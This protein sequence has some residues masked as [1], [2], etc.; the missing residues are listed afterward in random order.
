MSTAAW[1]WALAGILVLV[2]IVVIVVGALRR[3]SGQTSSSGAAMANAV[4]RRGVAPSDDV[5][6]EAAL[7]DDPA[8]LRHAQDI[9]GVREDGQPITLPHESSPPQPPTGEESPVPQ[10]AA[11]SEADAPPSTDSPQSEEKPTDTPQHAAPSTIPDDSAESKEADASPA[12]AD[13]DDE[14][15]RDEQG[16]RLDPY[17]NP[18]D[19]HPKGPTA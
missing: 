10:R 2:I 3:K 5:T 19:E 14:I 17:G 6:D 1:L 8:P 15:P 16:R 12:D 13:E 9:E 18:V 4:P 11:T 7:I